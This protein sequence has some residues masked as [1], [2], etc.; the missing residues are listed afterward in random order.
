MKGY[1]KDKKMRKK[2]FLFLLFVLIV[3]SGE[4]FAQTR[5]LFSTDNGLSNSLINR[6]YQDERGFV[7]IATEYGLNRFDGIQFE[8]YKH[9][10]DDPTSLCHNYVRNL[11]ED[12]AGRF[13]IGTFSGLMEYNRDTD[14][15]RSIKMFKEGK[16][17]YPHITSMV[18][19]HN[20]DIWLTTSGHGV[21]SNKRGEDHF[22]YESDLSGSLSS[23]YLNS[24]YEDSNLR[25][26]IGSENDGLN[27][28]DPIVGKIRLFKAPGD[29]SSNNISAFE[30]DKRGNV[31]VGTLTRGLNI[32]KSG[33]DKFEH[34]PYKEG[35]Q[36]FI[37]SLVI[38]DEGHLFIGTDGQGLK[39]YSSD[40]NIIEDYELSSAPFNFANGKIHSILIDREKNTWL[41]FFQKGVFFIP[42]A[43]NKFDYFGF[44]SMNY[45]SIGSN[46]VTAIC[47]DSQGVIW[48]GTD[49]DGIYGVNERGQRLS[50][51][52]KTQSPH[53]VPNIIH[54]IYED[55]WGNMWLGSYTD[56]LALFNK[57]TGHCEYIK[58]FL[59]E[60]VYSITQ[61]KNQNILV[62]TFGS[63]FYILDKSGNVIEHYESSKREMDLLTVDEL[64]NDW[65]NTLM[66]DKDGLIWIG[67]FKGLSCFDPVKK[68]FLNYHAKNNILPGTVV[69]S[70][71]Q[72]VDGIIWIG[73]SSGL[74]SFDKK[75]LSLKSYTTKD[76]LSNDVICGI[77][78]DDENNLW[79]STYR[80]ISKYKA[81]EKRFINYYAS[82]GLQG[83]EFSR[84]AVFR[85]ND[86][87]IFLGG[88]NGVSAFYPPLIVEDRK[89]LNVALTNFYLSNNPIKKGDRSGDHDIIA[90]S[91]LDADMIT[92]GSED[93]TFSFEFSTFEFSNPER[94]SFQ[95]R[96]ENLNNE[97]MTTAPGVNRVTYNNLSPG[98]YNFHV[99]AYDNDNFSPIKSIGL[100]IH[101]PWYKSLW[102][103]FFYVLL[104]ILVLYLIV[105]F[106]ISKIRHREELMQKDHAEKI[107]E[108]KLQF[109]I[110]ISHE[111]RTPMT[112]I[113]NPLE[114]LIKDNKDK[115]P[116]KQKIYLMIYRNAQ[117]I[118]RLINQL[119]D[120]RKLDKGQVRLSCRETDMVGFIEDLMLT[121]EYQAKKKNIDFSF[122]HEDKSLMAWIDLNNFD[123][124][125]LNILSNAFKY[126]PENGE[127]KVTLKTGYDPDNHGYLRNYFEIVISDTGIGI[128][129]D[130]IEKIFERFYQINNDTTN[131]N[132]GTG[133]GLHLSRSLVEL[134]HGI[135]YAENRN[136]SQGS[137]FVV[138]IPM[139]NN[140]YRI[141]ELENPQETINFV[142]SRL[143]KERDTVTENFDEIESADEQKNTTKAKTR[144]QV[145]IVEDEEEIR[146]YIKEEL[147]SDYKIL[148]APNGKAALDIIL[149]HKPD[150]IVSDV[151][152]PE[153]DGITLSRKIKQNINI[154]H[155]PIILLTAKSKTEDRLEGLEIGADAYIV[156]PFNTEILKQ[157][158][159]NLIANRERLKNKFAGRQQPD[160]K[161]DKIELKSSD[162]KLMERIMKVINENIANPQ[163]N[164]EMLAENVGMSR[165]HM[166]RKLK[167][168]TSQ[169]ARDFIKGIRLKQAATLLSEK[170]LSVSE[171]AYAT[172]FVN[173]SHFSNSFKEFYGVSPTEYVNNA[174]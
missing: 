130:Q 164:V 98:K 20:G 92:L 7:W 95:Y 154:N 4:M 43:E 121:F 45:N 103:Y 8:I 47:K 151:M 123:K 89:E 170:K 76:G 169:S 127:I 165:V 160:D 113:I 13:Y 129:K 105:N 74:Y 6:I 102:A 114:K 51:Y 155:I 93:N 161:I 124:I 21:F 14:S 90:T 9:S 147:S 171:A 70:L 111:I 57:K 29:I 27:C 34:I 140:H 109:F 132:F 172:G 32:L 25:I 118:L 112:L 69:Q 18:E 110:N 41:G 145:L 78:A 135:I 39:V 58:A 96:M 131:S 44:K 146:Q 73:T 24:I 159:D 22:T 144:Y 153:M 2:S 84:G 59:N 55:S 82:D 116:D 10:E 33:K 68:T 133:I 49:S 91:V 17:I 40:K 3:M 12:S 136:D 138:R 15:F 1:E 61:D 158:I 36:L 80:G 99:R 48:I 28:Y 66:S 141:D 16:L 64:S 56:G 94:I 115:D 119:M 38:N 88:I 79:I 150:L 106:I 30:E 60:K 81:D 108:A 85:D 107:S 166:H 120:I 35:G 71:F 83:N 163:L 77:I 50:H 87:K 117:R 31:Y 63:G 173:L 152:M 148:T 128:D 149:K 23:I 72:D 65:I 126:T 134:H 52:H 168:L 100:I 54:N 139:G 5:K 62:G 156:K 11:F 122:D 19:L 174:N 67:H 46:S 167:E 142:D 86:G 37:K 125:L 42:T 143:K 157:T 75:D 97:W 104:F 101:P 137:R 53:S 162:E 26:W